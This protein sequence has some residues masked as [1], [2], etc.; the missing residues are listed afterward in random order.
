MVYDFV[1]KIKNVKNLDVLN[2]EALEGIVD[3]INAKFD[4]PL[5]LKFV[6][7]DLDKSGEFLVKSQASISSMPGL[8]D[9]ELEAAIKA[10]IAYIEEIA[11]AIQGEVSKQ[12][13]FY[14]NSKTFKR[15][16]EF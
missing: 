4:A 13:G 9:K 10:F 7:P 16:F 15:L 11:V 3:E 1:S 12:D 8:H 14:N 2:N 6:L 5:D